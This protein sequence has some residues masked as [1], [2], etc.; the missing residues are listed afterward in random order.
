MSPLL[1]SCCMILR[2]VLCPLWGS[3]TVRDST[4]MLSGVFEGK[5]LFSASSGLFAA[6]VSRPRVLLSQPGSALALRPD[7]LSLQ[8][9]H[10]LAI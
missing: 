10:W 3:V 9:Q 6:I 5:G 1:Q 8:L 2:R 7:H 4:C